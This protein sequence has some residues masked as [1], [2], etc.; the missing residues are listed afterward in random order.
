M[1]KKKLT[2]AEQQEVDYKEW[3]AKQYS[4]ADLADCLVFA[5]PNGT[6]EELATR[7]DALG[8][9]MVS[10]ADNLWLINDAINRKRAKE[11]ERNKEFVLSALNDPNF[12]SR[13]VLERAIK[14]FIREC[15]KS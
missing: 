9:I 11:L 13:D 5:Y 10:H 14:S 7:L 6:P 1:V 12:V 15:H 3:S 4:L 8:I 2:S